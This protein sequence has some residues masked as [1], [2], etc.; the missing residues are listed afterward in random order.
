MPS[1]SEAPAGVGGT[2][3]FTLCVSE[4]LHYGVSHNFTAAMPQLHLK[5]EA[6]HFTKNYSMVETQ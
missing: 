1:A 5:S 6:L 4:I 3:N 2:L